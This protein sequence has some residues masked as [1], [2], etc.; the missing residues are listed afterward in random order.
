MS[1]DTLLVG[2]R[3]SCSAFFQPL[4]C[5]SPLWKHFIAIIFHK[6][7]FPRLR[8]FAAS[9]PPDQYLSFK[10]KS[11]TGR[12]WAALS[13]GLGTSPPSPHQ[14]HSDNNIIRTQSV[15]CNK[16]IFSFRSENSLSLSQSG[17]VMTTLQHQSDL[18]KFQ[19]F[20]VRPPGPVPLDLTG[21]QVKIKL[22]SSVKT[23]QAKM[24]RPS[25][26]WWVSVGP[27]IK[28]YRAGNFV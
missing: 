14:S 13:A 5:L 1:R 4:L 22:R 28:Q 19:S 16:T 24:C 6:I 21:D 8:T 3:V 7:S 20:S 2:V 17:F 11:S 26:L 23:S 18:S 10:I 25:L 12:V 27:N 9:S 15:K